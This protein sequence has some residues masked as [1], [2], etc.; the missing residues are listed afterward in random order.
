MA[1]RPAAVAAPEPVATTN[2]DERKNDRVASRDWIDQNGAVTNDETQ[3]SGFR[4]TLRATG[5]AI[6]HQFTSAPGS[7]E[8][9][10][11]VFGAL[12]KLGNEVNTHKAKTGEAT[13]DP[14]RAFWTNL[15][16]TG[17]WGVPGTGGGGPRINFERLRDAVRERAQ[18]L[19]TSPEKPLAALEGDNADYAKQ[20]LRNPGIAEIYRRLAGGKVT[21]DEEI[22]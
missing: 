13:L 12:T 7:V 6:E 15:V 14:A 2:G 5:D 20:L 17:R 8:T 22:F 9:Q 11:A 16:D 19:G 10:C 1:K 3:V 4:L 21:A 18:E